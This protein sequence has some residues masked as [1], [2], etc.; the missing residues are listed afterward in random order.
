[1]AKLAIEITADARKAVDSFNATTTSLGKLRTE[2]ASAQNQQAKGVGSTKQLEDATEAYLNKIQ[3]Q[4]SAMMSGSLSA[5]DL[6]KALNRLSNEQ[7]KLS[8]IMDSNESVD[9]TFA[10]MKTYYEGLRDELEI[11]TA[12]QR[13]FEKQSRATAE[14]QRLLTD[15]NASLAYYD[16]IGDEL[17][18]AS[19]QLDI[20]ERKLRETIRTNGKDSVEAKKLADSIKTQ[21]V[22]IDGLAKASQKA[23]PSIKGL[24]KEFAKGQLLASGVESALRKAVQLFVEAGKVAAHAEET[25]NLFNTTFEDVQNVAE[26]IASTIQNKMGIANSSAKEALGIFGDLALSYGQTQSAALDFAES[27][28]KTTLDLIS[29]K[30]IE[31]DTVEI[32]RNFSSGLVG[33][34]ENFKKLGIIVTATEIDS[35]LAAKGMQNLT[36]AAAQFAKAQEA[37]LIVQ[38]KSQNAFGD[39]EKTLNST[40]NITRRVQ[41]ENKTL[42]ENLGRHSNVILNPFKL[43]WLEIA[44]AINRA[45]EA[46]RQFAAGAKDINVFDVKGSFFDRSKFQGDVTSTKGRLANSMSY[47]PGNEEDWISRAKDD[48]REILIKYNVE[49]EDLISEINRTT[50]SYNDQ[51]VGLVDEIAESVELEKKLQREKD[52]RTEMLEAE[53]S[54][55]QNFVNALNGLTG[56]QTAVDFSGTI[57]DIPTTAASASKTSKVLGSIDTPINLAIDNAIAGISSASWKSFSDGVSLAL[58]TASEKS[59]LEKKL[60]EVRTLYELLNNEVLKDGI[61]GDEEVAQL[62][63]V[64]NI[65][66]DV[67]KELAG[68]TEEQKRI[69]S[70]DSVLG[71]VAGSTSTMEH[72]IAKFGMSDMDAALYDLDVQKDLALS[73]AKTED[74]INE[75]NEKFKKLVE[76]TTE[77]YT[78]LEN[79]NKKLPDLFAG[80]SKATDLRGD[81]GAYITGINASSA[82]SGVYGASSESQSLF[83]QIMK[84]GKEEF[85]ALCESMRE[86][87]PMM[88]NFG[89][90][91]EEAMFQLETAAREAADALDEANWDALAQDA[92]SSLGG[93]VGDIVNASMGLGATGNIAMDLIGILIDLASQLEIVQQASSIISDTV[94][95][96]LNQLLSPLAGILTLIVDVLQEFLAELLQPIYTLISGLAPILATIVNMLRPLLQILNMFSPF[97][98]LIMK[99]LVLIAGTVNGVLRVIQD[100][101]KWLAGWIMKGVLG[102]V[103]GCIDILNKIPFVNIRRVDT[104]KYDEWASKDLSK[105]FGEGFQEVEDEINKSNKL[106]NDIKQ[107]TATDDAELKVYDKMFNEGLINAD[108]YSAMIAAHNG[109]AAPDLIKQLRVGGDGYVDYQNMGGKIVATNNAF[110]VTINGTNLSKEELERAIS[111]GFQKAMSEDGGSYRNA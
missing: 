50:N 19:K 35:R 87:N 46:Q 51:L 33:N 85:D 60:A 62:Q 103:N 26:K 42:M 57:S 7:K 96:V 41:E 4:E 30:N 82:P 66:Q 21:K 29:F 39:M 40:A 28:V 52:Q 80:S 95:P 111:R 73:Y 25:V 64:A 107:N 83:D 97:I 55:A 32:M 65:F 78:L 110:Q 101:L 59:G 2:L 31:G 93:E 58:G 44:S 91:T 18:K 13:E 53:L 90:N 27:A 63:K 105:S 81:W 34:Y 15:D 104:S 11:A 109:E 43:A 9:K 49:A 67:N 47:A 24:F 99:G 71:N 23:T 5:K 88:Q 74:E 76:A 45:E 12:K 8:A 102:L 22:A 69:A 92:T 72:N 86:A 56:V 61:V 70:L 108:E 20:Y 100:G 10:S 6:E 68:I 94:L 84:E 79:Q 16:L 17:G 98:D 54:S 38:E 48:L 89:I 36:G 75:V 37:L 77:Y 14:A 106:L 3:R 1:M